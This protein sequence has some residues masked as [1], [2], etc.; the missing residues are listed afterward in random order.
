MPAEWVPV[1]V[2]LLTLALASNASGEPA[3]ALIT[4]ANCDPF[5]SNAIRCETGV[6]ALKNATQLVL[7]AAIAPGPL[8]GSDP[9]AGAELAGAELL[10]G[11]LLA[12]GEP[13]LLLPQAAKVKTAAASSAA[14]SADSLVECRLCISRV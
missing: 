7:I 12:G 14:G 1:S 5:C 2:T 8:L 3:C 13:E 4:E 9:V 11:A 10:P 6:L